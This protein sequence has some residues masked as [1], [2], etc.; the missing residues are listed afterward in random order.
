MKNTRTKLAARYLTALR[1]HIGRKR[2][3]AGARAQT[4][5]RAALACGLATRDLAFMHEQAVVALTL[6]DDFV[7]AGNGTIKRAGYFFTQALIPLEAAQKATRATNRL[8]EQRN[9]TLRLHT[10]ALARA[11]HRLESEITRR[12]AG[13]GAIRQ[14]KEQYQQLFAES[15]IMQR[16]LR[17]VTRQIISANEPQTKVLAKARSPRRKSWSPAS[18]ACEFFPGETLPPRLSKMVVPVG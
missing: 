10:A 8:L 3:V 13:E 11:N 12:K 5:G 6:A 4:L 9:E 18:L 7:A 16:K 2:S 14:A 1:S 15:Q 17:E